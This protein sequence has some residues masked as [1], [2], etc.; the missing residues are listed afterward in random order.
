MPK[1]SIIVPVYNVEKYL[2]KCLDSLVNQTMQ[3]IEIILVNDASPD[4]S[5]VIMREYQQNYPKIIKCIFLKENV[6]LGGARNRGL[7]IATGDYV[8]FVD[9]DDWIDL[10]YIEKLYR[11]AADTGCDIVYADYMMVSETGKEPRAVIYPQLCGKLDE[12]K[13]KINLLSTG[14]W[15][16]ACIVRRGLILENGLFFREK[17]MY[18]DMAVCPLYTYYAEHIEQVENTYYYYYQREDSI[19]HNIDAEYQKDEAKA[20]IILLEACNERGITEKYPEEV[21]AMFTKYFYAWGMYGIYHGKFSRLPDEYM[22][23]L[24]KEM[25]NRFPHY[26][27]NVYFYTN[28]EPDLIQY[29]FNNDRKWIGVDRSYKETVS[30][31]DCY[32]RKCVRTKIIQLFNELQ[33]KKIVLWGAGKKGREFLQVLDKRYI[34]YVVDKSEKLAGNLMQTGE[35][36]LL[37]DDGLEQ[38]DVVLIANKNYYR[39]IKNIVKDKNSSIKIINIDIYLLSGF[40]VEQCME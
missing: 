15:A 13:R 39:Q 4:G 31:L 2:R 40:S 8:T 16:W 3:D 25:Q 23:Y 1:V 30:Y 18:E 17:M 5:D 37:P 32:N 36:I 19:T 24:A 29:M 20:L 14:I 9:S 35:I 34:K 6:R 38:A 12:A 22:K 27:D 21:E 7:E 26:Q 33:N 28:I 11:K 10:D